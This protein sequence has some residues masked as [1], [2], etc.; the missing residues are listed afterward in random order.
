MGSGQVLV[1]GGIAVNPLRYPTP[2]CT[3]TPSNPCGAFASTNT[4]E[5]WDPATGAWTAGPTM[6]QNRYG[7]DQLLL[8]NGKVLITGGFG[9]RPPPVPAA[10]CSRM[11][12][13]RLCKGSA[14]NQW[15]RL[16]GVAV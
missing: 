7:H 8:P 11:R 4:S 2:P 14:C 6:P 3:L 5:L 9:E 13:A 1:T 10:V 12:P 16:A 15:R